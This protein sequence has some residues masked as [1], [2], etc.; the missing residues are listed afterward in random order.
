[1]ATGMSEDDTDDARGDERGAPPGAPVLLADSLTRTTT[2]FVPLDDGVVRMYSCG[3]TVY[4]RAHL[5]NMRAYIFADTVRRALLWKGWAVRHI[6]NIT[7]VGHLLADAD[8]GDDKVEEAAKREAR[9]VWDL[10]RHYTDLF[11]RDFH[12][13][14]CL[15]PERWTVATE[16]VER[17]ILF[18]QRLADGG[19]AYAL[20]SGLYF[21]TTSIEGY[22]AMATM[23]HDDQAEARIDTVEGKRHPADFA[24][25]RT[26]APDEP[27]HAMQWDSPWG[28]GAPGWHLE[29]SVMSIETLGDH[30]DI[31]T[32]G[33]DHREVHHPN[34]DAQSRAWL[35]DGEP[36]VGR[37]MHVEFVQFGGDKMSKS[38][39]NVLDL[40]AVTDAG[41]DP[42]AY[43]LLLL[44]SS[45]R[46]QVRVAADDLASS[47]TRFER[48]VDSVRRRLPD[49]AGAATIDAHRPLLDL[50]AALAATATD[51]VARAYVE[52][53]DAAISDNLATPTVLVVVGDALA[54][55]DLSASGLTTVLD[56]VR[57]VLGIDLLACAAAA[58][59]VRDI[60]EETRAAI[61]A[62]VDERQAARGARDFARA[63]ALR[64]ELADTWD[65]TLTDGPNGT[66]WSV[67]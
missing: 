61:Q 51:P 8:L 36:W 14:G 6:I 28:V 62:L 33:V 58:L 66:T 45:Y 60:D 56:A 55:G 25:W 16:Y 39:G 3:P 53:V 19:H 11:Q 17:M 54:D 43:R 49:V 24:L 63:D 42:L 1:M 22:G 29:C 26:F 35:A 18:A 27:E 23:V 31:H 59:P 44:A 15:D 21:D 57:A 4:S 67:G 13:L 20:P 50:P 2:P 38:K 46:A 5:G 41:V 40:D 34:E 10:T 7:D 9:T 30:F 12:A 64:D 52:R 32:G 37:W 65:V 47:G 48:L